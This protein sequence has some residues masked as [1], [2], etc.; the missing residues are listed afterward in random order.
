MNSVLPKGQ[1]LLLPGGQGGGP[2]GAVLEAQRLRRHAACRCAEAQG[3]RQLE[4]RPRPTSGPQR[5]G[6]QH[7][8]LGGQL[9][10]LGTGLESTALALSLMKVTE[11][12]CNCRGDL[13]TW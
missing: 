1:V 11:F 9:P 4:P 6:H 8:A 10:A 5:T 3:D 7:V 12:L 2:R 13:I